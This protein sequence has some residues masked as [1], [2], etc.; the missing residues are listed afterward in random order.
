M[1]DLVDL[2][3]VAVLYTTDDP[4]VFALIAEDRALRELV[5]ALV[6]GRNGDYPLAWYAKVWKE[7]DDDQAA[8]LASVV[9]GRD[10]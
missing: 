5:W 7:L 8:L 2:E 10:E 4:T 6:K 9:D 3:G 1:A